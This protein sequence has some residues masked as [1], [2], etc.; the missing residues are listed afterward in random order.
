MNILFVCTGNSCRS[1]L[2]ESYCQKAAAETG[3]AEI[4]AQSAGTAAS[5]GSIS[6]NARQVMR[7]QD[8]APASE[9][10]RAVGR[11]LVEWADIILTMTAGHKQDLEYM[12]PPARGKT[13][14]LGRYTHQG[15][16][17]S[18]PIWGTLDDY[19]DCFENIKEAVDNFLKSLG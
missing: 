14:V 13:E 6:R 15:G 9:Q 3:L 17:I 7:E 16:D 12:F 5:G 18:D 8:I 4:R 2:A 1:P 11:E 10:S 19:R